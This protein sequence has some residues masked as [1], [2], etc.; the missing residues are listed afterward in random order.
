MSVLP[1]SPVAFAETS[2]AAWFT[3]HTIGIKSSPPEPEPVSDLPALSRG[4]RVTF[5]VEDLRDQR[6]QGRRR[7]RLG[8][9]RPLAVFGGKQVGVAGDE[10]EGDAHGLQHL[11]Y[12]EHR[13]AAEA[14]VEQRKVDL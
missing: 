1:S 5:G 6:Q 13:F 9:K 12:G 14:N 2:R 8:E 7:P 3:P 11:R 4:I 10:D